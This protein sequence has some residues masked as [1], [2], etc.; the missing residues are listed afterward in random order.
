MES[1]DEERGRWKKE[2][3]AQSLRRLKPPPY[4]VGPIN[5]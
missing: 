2:I 4:S 3:V 5:V 1:E